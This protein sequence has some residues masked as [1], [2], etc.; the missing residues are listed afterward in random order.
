MS[1]HFKTSFDFTIKEDI[2][3]SL[4]E[5]ITIYLSISSCGTVTEFTFFSQ[6]QLSPDSFSLY[7]LLA[8]T[9]EGL[10]CEDILSLSWVDIIE[11]A[12]DDDFS[13]R[14]DDG[15]LPIVC[16]PLFLLHKIISKFLGEKI[17]DNVDSENDDIVCFCFA[18]KKSEIVSFLK[19]TPEAKLIDLT[20]ALNVTGACQSCVGEVKNIMYATR[21]SSCDYSKLSIEE[22][23]KTLMEW[24]DL[25]NYFKMGLMH[26]HSKK[27]DQLE[28]KVQ[29]PEKF[30]DL[31]WRI[32]DYLMSE[33]G[34]SFRVSFISF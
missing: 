12:D 32:E 14:Y 11:V 3:T 20:N 7:A 26:L 2:I 21:K 33:L 17:L 13:Q 24:S 8:K 22:L 31:N 1:N 15:E 6:Q 16:E 25:T 30:S 10:A 9:T 5:N 4:D 23:E 19:S 27:E 34:Y 28:F 18:V 29:N